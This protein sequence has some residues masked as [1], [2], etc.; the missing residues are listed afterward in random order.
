M[1]EDSARILDIYVYDLTFRSVP[2]YG[3]TTAVGMFTA[4]INLFMLLGANQVVYKLTGDKM[5]S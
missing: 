1:V 2:D 4:V 5:F 3:F